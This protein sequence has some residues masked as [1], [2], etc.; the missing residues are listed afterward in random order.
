MNGLFLIDDNKDADTNEAKQIEKAAEEKK[1]EKKPSQK[2]KLPTE[3]VN[4]LI[5]KCEKEGVPVDFIVKAYKVK[6]VYQMTE[7]QWMNCIE[8]W[9]QIREA[10]GVNGE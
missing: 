5:A 8:C 10:A 3:K 7:A 6:T 2:G 9:E 4:A 1:E